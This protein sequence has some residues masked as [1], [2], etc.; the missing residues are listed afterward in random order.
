[1]VNLLASFPTPASITTLSAA[2][3]Q[4]RAWNLVGR[5]VNKRAL[6]A[7]VYAV[8]QQSIGVPVALDS[9]AITMFQLI[10]EQYLALNQPRERI[11]EQAATLLADHPDSSRRTATLY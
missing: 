5:K 1:M 11:A 3:F 8:A 6:L 4:T 10:L 9:P 7:E 2:E